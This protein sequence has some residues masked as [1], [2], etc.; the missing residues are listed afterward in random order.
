MWPCGG[1][2][3]LW[4]LCMSITMKWMQ[5]FCLSQNTFHR[6]CSPDE[7][8]NGQQKMKWVFHTRPTFELILCYAYPYLGLKRSHHTKMDIFIATI[9]A[10]MSLNRAQTTDSWKLIMTSYYSNWS[11]WNAWSSHPK[12]CYCKVN[13][14]RSSH[15]FFFFAFDW[16]HP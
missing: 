5:V 16:C 14:W 15:F 7:Q 1:Y 12:R 3:I 11:G 4:I 2:S 8:R 10:T 9:T 13:V 6:I